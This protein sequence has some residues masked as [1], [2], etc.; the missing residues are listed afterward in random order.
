M[1]F[2]SGIEQALCILAMLALQQEHKP[3]RSSLIS[4]QLAVSDSYLKKIMRQLVVCGLVISDSG[5][6]GGFRL[7]RPLSKISLLDVFNVIESKEH[8]AQSTNLAGRVFH[9]PNGEQKR[10]TKITSAFNRAEALYRQQL[11]EFNLDQL[12][13][14]EHQVDWNTIIHLGREA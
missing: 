14:I 5:R 1:K 8:F 2:K 10:Q 4:E 11:R 3:L 12:L 7:A 13:T 9:D 6:E